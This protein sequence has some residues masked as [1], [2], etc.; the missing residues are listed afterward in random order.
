MP[1]RLTRPP[2]K[3]KSQMAMRLARQAPLPKGNRDSRRRRRPTGRPVAPICE[4]ATGSLGGC[5][6]EHRPQ[7]LPHPRE[8]L[9]DLLEV[10]VV[11]MPLGHALARVGEVGLAD[12]Q[13]RRLAHH[14][15]ARLAEVLE[16]Q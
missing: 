15:A 8:G 7:L 2:M 11:V 14:V 13:A 3:F 9:R 4:R 16:A 1:T 12:L 10:D 5:E 6:E